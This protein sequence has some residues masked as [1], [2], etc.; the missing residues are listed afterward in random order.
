VLTERGTSQRD[1]LHEADGAVAAVNVHRT[2]NEHLELDRP[3]M[4]GAPPP[5]QWSVHPGYRITR[6]LAAALALLARRDQ[7]KNLV[8]AI[9]HH[10]I[11][12]L[13]SQSAV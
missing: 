6:F 1:L 7:S 11:F 13:A 4:T 10:A 3:A 2:G 9:F 5:L 8:D 12:G